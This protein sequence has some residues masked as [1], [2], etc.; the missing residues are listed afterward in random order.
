M[1]KEMKD[2]SGVA[3]IEGRKRLC[4]RNRASVQEESGQ[5]PD[6]T[7]A[8]PNDKLK[9]A[10]SI[11][12]YEDDNLL[13]DSDNEDA[14]V[15]ETI[16]PTR[17][18]LVRGM[19][20]LRS[21]GQSSTVSNQRSEVTISAAA[22][23]DTARYRLSIGLENQITSGHRQLHLPVD[24]A[25][26]VTESRK[27]LRKGDFSAVQNQ[28]KSMER[29]NLT[30]EKVSASVA[31]EDSDDN[32]LDDSE[33][34]EHDEEVIGS[35]T[36]DVNRK[37]G[38]GRLSKATPVKS[39]P[40]NQN[41]I[42]KE[43]I[44]VSLSDD[45]E[46]SVTNVPVADSQEHSSGAIK[47]ASS[48]SS[49]VSDCKAAAG[50]QRKDSS[51]TE[52]NYTKQMSC[53]VTVP[54]VLSYSRI[55]TDIDDNILDDSDDDAAYSHGNEA[56]QN[57]QDS[58]RGRLLKRNESRTISGSVQSDNV[59][60]G[61]NSSKNILFEDKKGISKEHSL[62]STRSTSG[63]QRA[64]E[65]QNTPNLDNIIDDE[66]E[67]NTDDSEY[68][69]NGGRDRDEEE[70]EEEEEED[71][72]DRS[73]SIDENFCMNFSSFRT[74]VFSKEVWEMQILR[75]DCDDSPETDKEDGEHPSLPLSSPRA[76]FPL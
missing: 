51:K 18:R 52:K 25:Y 64:R 49:K 60:M 5:L 2:E 17:T 27:R 54:T 36:R 69:G 65:E 12:D 53:V 47:S 20:Q 14:D 15:A 30:K 70:E 26:E 72:Q 37:Q 22:K 39:T 33:N 46:D 35:R 45:R 74:S 9:G 41:R 55:D 68:G 50:D 4:R 66:S 58:T 32:L 10:K 8:S 7:Q 31:A 6:C 71:G 57:S 75:A 38:Q 59:P 1:V 48:S 62:V 67:C 21:R 16:S 29:S 76:L 40:L 63:R 73:C 28:E 19:K 13:D 56:S 3:L 23:D 44:H 34:S 43:S 42:E 24:A 61:K 11:V